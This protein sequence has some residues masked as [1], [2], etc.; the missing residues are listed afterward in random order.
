MERTLALDQ[1]ESARGILLHELDPAVGQSAAGVDGAKTAAVEHQQA[2]TR[3]L[4]V[5][6]LTD[7]EKLQ[8]AFRRHGNPFGPAG[9]EAHHAIAGSRKYAG[10][11]GRHRAHPAK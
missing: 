7:G 10:T 2:A 1:A 3:I 4:E 11:A 5:N 6:A 9:G 8:P